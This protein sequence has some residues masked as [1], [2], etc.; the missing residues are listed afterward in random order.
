MN[1]LK[2]CAVYW[3]RLPEHTDISFQGYV[4]VS[5]YPEELWGQ[6]IYEITKNKHL[7]QHLTFAVKKYGWEN[8]VKE[9]VFCGYEDFCYVVENQYRPE[10]NIGWNIAP[11]GHRGP[12]LPD[13]K[14]NPEWWENYYKKKEEKYQKY[15]ESDAYNDWLECYEQGEKDMA[16]REAREKEREEELQKNANKKY[17]R[18]TYIKSI[19]KWIEEYQDD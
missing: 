9:T 11:G 5:K 19:F 15:L 4:G 3:I 6:H 12:G 7:N 2:Q 8:I 16:E 14:E 18:Y 17:L 13:K 10:K 1:L